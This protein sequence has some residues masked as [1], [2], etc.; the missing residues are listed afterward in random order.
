[1]SNKKQQALQVQIDTL[2]TQPV[3][4]AAKTGNFTYNSKIGGLQLTLSKN[5]A[6]IVNVDGNAGGAP[7]STFRVGKLAT[8]GI[9]EDNINE[10]I[11]IDIAHS[12]STTL[13]EAVNIVSSRLKE[14]SFSNIK[15]TDVKVDDQTAK[16]VTADGV[17]Y[18]ANRRVYIVK[19]GDFTYEIASKTQ[20][21][22]EDSAMLKAVLDGINIEAKKLN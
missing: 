10:W 17:G 13:D 8:E 20:N 5:Y 7:G 3:S 12:A 2:K 14:A 4:D 21:T 9:I 1:M 6:L 11:Q 18:D 15:V 22:G 19:S 16:L